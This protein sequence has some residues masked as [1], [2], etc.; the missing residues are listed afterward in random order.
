MKILDC[1]QS[2][3]KARIGCNCR[4]VTYRKVYMFRFFNKYMEIRKYVSGI[5]KKVDKC[6]ELATEIFMES[7]IRR[8][9]DLERAVNDGWYIPFLKTAEV[10]GV[11]LGGIGHVT[12]NEYLR[13]FGISIALMAGI[14]HTAIHIIQSKRQK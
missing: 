14:Y 13:G 3:G 10:T 8:G 11:T 12:N 4:M 6:D 1:G 7:V 2:A 5:M 9:E